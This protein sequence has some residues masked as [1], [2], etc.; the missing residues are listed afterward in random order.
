MGLFSSIKSLLGLGNQQEVLKEKSVQ[1]FNETLRSAP[2]TTPDPVVVDTNDVKETLEV[3]VEEPK[4]EKKIVV[5]KES[6]KVKAE[7]KKPVTEKQK[8]K[9]QDTK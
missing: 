9:K 8:T 2:V 6:P 3:K 5:K 1:T 4:K 7:T